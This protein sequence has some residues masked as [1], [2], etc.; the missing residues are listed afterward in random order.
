MDIVGTIGRIKGIRVPVFVDR[1]ESVNK[2][3]VLP[4]QVI[5]LKVG[6]EKELTITLEE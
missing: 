2:L 6:T 4:T 5:G 1:L 3:M